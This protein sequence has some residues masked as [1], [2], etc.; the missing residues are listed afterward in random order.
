MLS[1]VDIAKYVTR[2]DVYPVVVAAMRNLETRLLATDGEELLPILGATVG[3][4]VC[5]LFCKRGARTLSE[6]TKLALISVNVTIDLQWINAAAHVGPLFTRANLL[7]PVAV[8]AHFLT[9]RNLRWN[10]ALIGN[11]K[12][13]VE[14]ILAKEGEAPLSNK[15]SHEVGDCTQ[16]QI[17]LT[18]PKA[19]HIAF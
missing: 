9:E 2:M 18:A 13:V 1:A 4:R 5:Q 3:L 10:G 19:Q 11:G 6:L 7:V 14:W 15:V 16:G 8:T 17:R 12:L